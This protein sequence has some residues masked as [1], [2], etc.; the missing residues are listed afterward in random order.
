MKSCKAISWLWLLIVMELNFF[1]IFMSF[2]EGSKTWK[3]GDKDEE[4][5]IFRFSRRF[6]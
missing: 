2:K 1:Y 3:V 4:L 5:N 6:G